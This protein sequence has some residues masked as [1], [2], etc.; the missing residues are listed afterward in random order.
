MTT[1]NKLFGNKTTKEDKYKG[2]SFDAGLILKQLGGN[3]F[4]AMTGAKNFVKDDK[5]KMIAFK[6]G[7]NSKN[8]NYVRIKLNSMDTYDMEFINMRAGKMTVRSKA[9]GIYN[10]QLESVFTE[11]TGMY[12]KLF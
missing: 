7:R 3:K 12:T 10:D 6:I 2:N 4:I 1:R 11:N 5:S 9:N 8:V